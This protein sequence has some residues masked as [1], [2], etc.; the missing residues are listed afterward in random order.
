MKNMKILVVDDEASMRK[1]IETYLCQ[2]GYLVISVSNG[3]E[4]VFNV[5]LG[6]IDLVLLDVVMPG[7]NGWEVCKRIRR[8]S[9][10]SILMLTARSDTADKVKGLNLG[11]D[12]YLTKP[13][14]EM[15]LVARIKAL[16]RRKE[17]S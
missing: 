3:L 13:F 8:F 11:A 7:M 4:A 1:L 15:E 10:V 2:N 6:D 16:L 14:E 17:K 9:D 5:M 12:G